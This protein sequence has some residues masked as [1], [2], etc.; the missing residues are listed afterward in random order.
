LESG[1]V[2][3]CGEK[4]A[5]VERVGRQAGRDIGKERNSIRIGLGDNR[6]RASGEIDERVVA[7]TRQ[8]ASPFGA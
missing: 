5:E 2:K 6:G 8:I 3:A 7:G 4:V 1:A